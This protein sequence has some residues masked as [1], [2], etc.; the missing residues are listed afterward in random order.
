M[1]LCA[2]CGLAQL[3]GADDVTEEPLG[4]E[5]AALVR[6]RAAALELLA[7]ARRGPPC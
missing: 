4:F 2:G 3:V 1:W 5:P 7:T 6:Q